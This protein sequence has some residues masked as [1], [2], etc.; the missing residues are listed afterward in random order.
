MT[1][2]VAADYILTAHPELSLANFGVPYHSLKLPDHVQPIPLDKLHEFLDIIT[3]AYD[4]QDQALTELWGPDS[5]MYAELKKMKKSRSAYGGILPG[6]GHRDMGGAGSR[7]C[8]DAGG[9]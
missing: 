4:L 5:K 3:L 2:F 8:H 7:Q 6:R 1:N 9:N